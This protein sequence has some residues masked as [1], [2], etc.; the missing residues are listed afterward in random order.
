MHEP[1]IRHLFSFAW[2]SFNDYLGAG[3][4]QNIPIGQ[5]GL[6]LIISSSFSIPSDG[7]IERNRSTKLELSLSIPL[8]FKKQWPTAEQGMPLFLN[9][10]AQKIR[11][12]SKG[13]EED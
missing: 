3:V 5:A 12:C 1:W 11:V 13:G 8:P 4:R 2:E 10:S 6:E 7:I 9:T